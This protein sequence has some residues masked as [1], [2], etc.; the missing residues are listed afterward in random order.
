MKKINDISILYVEDEKGVREGL[1]DILKFFCT[2][3][4]IACDGV[5]GLELYKKYIPNIVISDIRMPNMDGV[6]MANKIRQIKESQHI[7]FTSA[8]SNDKYFIDAI[9]LQ[10]DGYILKPVN[11]EKLNKK[12]DSITKHIKLKKDFEK[13][14]AMTIQAD[15]LS[16]MKVMLE[17]IAHQWRQPLGSISADATGLVIQKQMNKLSDENF[18]KNCESINENALHLSDTIDALSKF[19]EDEKQIEN[20]NLK[21]SIDSVLNLLEATIIEHKIKVVNNTNDNI[22][23]K[24][25]QNEFKQALINIIINTKD[26]LALE[27]DKFIFID[28]KQN[29]TSIIVSIKDNGGGIDEYILT[30]IF[31]P[32]FTTK[33]QSRGTGLGLYVSFDIITNILNGT[34]EVENKTFTHEDI[35]YTGA[36][37][38]I[39]LPL[40]I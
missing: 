26:A 8:H 9:E 16:S 23:I 19:I 28:I 34:L 17:N 2:E 7:I 12:I 3:L 18:Y 1:A 10:V 15:K 30:K 36:E 20:F 27:K 6:E 33:H 4:H 5:E 40:N 32:Y 24:S 39:T 14:Q 25:L 11:I 35:T 29:E 21:Y 38:T 31:E 13:Q 37:F 22:F